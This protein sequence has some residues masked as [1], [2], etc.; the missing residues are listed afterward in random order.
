MA[1]TSTTS[2]SSSR[3][4]MD[5]RTGRNRT[6]PSESSRRSNSTDLTSPNFETDEDFTRLLG[7]YDIPTAV[8]LLRRYL[9]MEVQTSV[10]ASGSKQQSAQVKRKF[11]ERFNQIL[12]RLFGNDA[13][14]KQKYGGWL[15]YSVG[16]SSKSSSSSSNH[17]SREA[18]LKKRY[19]ASLINPAT[20]YQED[21][22]RMAS[23]VE[24]LTTSGRALIDFLGFQKED[25]AGSIFQFLFKMTHPVEFK[26]E[27]DMLPEQTKLSILSRSAF[28][29]VLFTQLLSKPITKQR[30]DPR[31]PV[32]LVSIKELY[33]FYFMRHPA[34]ATHQ[35]S[36]VTSEGANGDTSTRSSSL[37]ESISDT[38]TRSKR[39]ADYSWRSFYTNGVVSLTN[40]NPYN[41]LLLQYLK[42]FFPDSNQPIQTRFHGKVLHHSNLFLH[43]L[44]EFWLRQNLIVFS[45]DTGLS[46]SGNELQNRMTPR[47]VSP[48]ATAHTQ[49]TYMA[50]SDD[51][52]SSLLLTIIHLLSDSFY[53]A[54]MNEGTTGSTGY[55]SGMAIG[56]GGGYLTPSIS[57]MRRP[58]YEFFRLV[59]SRAPIGLSPTAFYAITDVW[60]AYLQPWNCPMWMK[61]QTSETMDSS[62]TYTSK[63]ET[64]VLANY[65]FYT[66]LLGVFI[67]RAKELD[68]TGSDERSH[69][70]LDRVLSVFTPDLLSL[71]RQAATFFDKNQPYSF[72]S[73]VTKPKVK[74]MDHEGLNPA[75]GQILTYYCK[76]LGLESVGVPL[77]TSYHRDAERVFDKLWSDS[78]FT[79][80]E[81]PLR[82][83]L[84]KSTSTSSSSSSSW[85]RQPGESTFERVHRLSRQLRRVF[86]ISDA[87]VTSTAH[88]RSLQTYSN[89]LDDMAPNR[90]SILHHLLTIRGLLQL[91]SGDRL[92]APDQVAY[93]GDPMLRPIC[94]FEIPWLVRLSYRFSTWCN[95]QMGLQNPYQGKHFEDNVYVDPS[96]AF[97]SF[98]FNF[99]FLASKPNLMF[100]SAVLFLLYVLLLW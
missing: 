9:A 80:S 95:D 31:N 45:E 86:E 26:L 64:F 76:A 11:Y 85:F 73:Y 3:R 17:T 54:S 66:T 96:N 65:H 47:L 52:H 32:L 89:G 36:S 13:I 18:A 59:F 68:L 83:P 97:T 90:H 94:T 12:D 88:S 2:I 91:R 44:I 35:T 74:N 84:S 82:S 71:L 87:Y 5:T 28:T 72:G 78:G 50:P 92:C 16:V 10:L 62:N 93:V 34:S 60:L 24:S 4:T 23:L 39:R 99:R 33:L 14:S 51:L 49:T 100:T 40:G 42:V 57:V 81:P 63:W 27:M 61:S 53:P 75:Q 46:T 48:F 21:Q 79:G 58:L 19:S 1:S 41:V 15:D 20:P 67:E 43:I 77:H 56:S 55:Y 37:M 6:G 25:E 29:S 22:L 69:V 30:M 38:F 98:R 7:S 70:I 8:E